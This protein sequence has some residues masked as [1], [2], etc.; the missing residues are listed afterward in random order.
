MSGKKKILI[1]KDKHGDM[2]YAA[3][4]EMERA[5]AYEQIFNA[6]LN[7]GYYCDMDNAEKNIQ[8]W[9]D[10]LVALESLKVDFENGKISSTLKKEAENQVKK[11]P[12]I[13]RKIS[14]RKRE[15]RIF[16]SAKDGNVK[17]KKDFIRDRSNY[18]Y[19]RIEFDIL[20]CPPTEEEEE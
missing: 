15:I 20:I 3:D 5:Y 9:Q 19:E 14:L 16:N 10:Q 17:S 12:G 6:M 4:T 8:S 7:A 1:W 2:I 11:I 13:N 18:E